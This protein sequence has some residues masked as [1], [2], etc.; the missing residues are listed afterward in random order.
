MDDRSRLDRWLWFTR[1]FRS[2]ALALAAVSA[3]HVRLN[4]ER[5]KPAHAVRPGDIVRIQRGATLVEATVR[6][7]PDRRGP[8]AQAS[9]CYEETATSRAAR[10]VF[11]ERMRIG[12]ALAPRPAERPGK[13]DRR[14]LRRARGRA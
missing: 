5:V 12:A 4:G 2:R 10:A 1:F 13:H 14:A 6:A 3:G 8:A 11:A 7:I 9:A